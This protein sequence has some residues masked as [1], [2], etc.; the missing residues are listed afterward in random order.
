MIS[1]FD[2]EIVFDTVTDELCEYVKERDNGMC[3]LCGR[4]GSEIHHVLFRSLGGTNKANNL[5]LLCVRC[6]LFRNSLCLP[7]QHDKQ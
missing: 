5:I 6:H 2:P 7:K 1:D 4:M 3:Q